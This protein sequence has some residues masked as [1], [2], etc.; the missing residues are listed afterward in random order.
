MPSDI[1]S[2]ALL[3]AL[4]DATRAARAAGPPGVPA[5][6]AEALAGLDLDS[7]D[8]AGFAGLLASVGVDLTG[9]EP[10]MA[11]VNTILDG[12]AARHP[13][14]PAGPLPVGPLRLSAPRPD[15]PRAG[16]PERSA[17]RASRAVK[18]FSASGVRSVRTI[19]ARNIVS[20]SRFCTSSHVH[21]PGR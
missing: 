15:P 7:L 14:G 4:T 19:I 6:L 1:P 12:P 10:E 13:R 20:P 21:P 17:M 18:S 11:V 16:M 3:A 8:D 9:G 5:G 2:A